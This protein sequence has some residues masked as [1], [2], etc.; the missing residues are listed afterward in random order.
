[1]QMTNTEETHVCKSCGFSG[2]EN[3]CRHCGQPYKT[4]R[5][6]MAGLLHDVFHFFTHLDKGFGYTL[7]MLII[8]P[9]HMQREYVEGVRSKHQKP[10]SMFFIC[11]TI[12]ALARYWIYQALL[13][14]YH[15]GNVSEMTFFH[16]YMVL[17]HIVLLPLNALIVYLFFYKS[18]YNYAETG[19]LFLYS[20]SFFFVVATVISLFK[21]I[22]PEFDTAYFELPVLL[23]YTIITNINFF[24]RQPRWQ[25]VIK[26]IIII[27]L[28]FLSVQVIED[29]V[30][31]LIS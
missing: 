21:F 5:I 10:F 9:G 7:K 1:M 25:V 3:Y 26:S 16:E 11:A 30:I 13:K 20:G 24:H 31:Q 14:Y 15:T 22:W 4:K 29:F 12:A 6:S 18:G 8:A 19:I 17:F 27:L 23:I 28:I 2:S